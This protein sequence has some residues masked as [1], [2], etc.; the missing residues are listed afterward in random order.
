MMF[1]GEFVTAGRRQGRL[2]NGA[3]LGL[4]VAGMMQFSGTT[5][6]NR[7]AEPWPAML[8]TASNNPDPGFVALQTRANA[9][10]ERL[11]QSESASEPL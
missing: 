9:A 6:A 7:N 1:D 5:N 2:W 3:V 10:L 4:L 11:V 8:G